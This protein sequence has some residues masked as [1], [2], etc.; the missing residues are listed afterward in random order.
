MRAADSALV[1]GAA[2]V[3]SM[4]SLAGAAGPQ[5]GLRGHPAVTRGGPWRSAS[6]RDPMRPRES[7]A[8]TAGCSAHRSRSWSCCSSAGAPAPSPLLIP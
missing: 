5:P 1:P 8:V 4:R 6:S 7:T 2:A 3:L